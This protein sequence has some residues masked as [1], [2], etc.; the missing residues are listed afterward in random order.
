MKC[1]LIKLNTVMSPD[2][3]LGGLSFFEGKHDISF[4]IKG[5]SCIYGAEEGT[6]RGF[7][8]HKFSSQLIF[9]PYGSVEVTLKDDK[10]TKVVL[11]DDPSKGLIIYP[12]VWRELKWK[13]GNSVLCIAVSDYYESDEITQDYDEYLDFLN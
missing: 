3:K 6:E 10:S 5:I 7:K 2:S 9:C 8:A 12:K 1:E 11:L 4:D 13:K